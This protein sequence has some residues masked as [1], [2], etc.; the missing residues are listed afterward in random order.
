MRRSSV[1]FIVLWARFPPNQD[2]TARKRC[3]PAPAKVRIAIIDA[4]ASTR[5]GISHF[6]RKTPEWEVIW[7]SATG[8][9]AAE[10]FSVEAPQMLILDIRLPDGSGLDL[11]K[12]FL[13]LNP[14]LLILVYTMESEEFYAWRC[15][16]A[17][18]CGY[19][20]KTALMTDFKTVL[21]TILQ[22]E[23]HFPAEVASKTLRRIR[24]RRSKNDRKGDHWNIH[25]LTD[26][27]IEVLQL[28]GLGRSSA[29]CAEL[30]GIKPRTL[31][32]H[33]ANIRTKIGLS[34]SL[35]LRTYATMLYIETN[36][37]RGKGR[38]PA[39]RTRNSDFSLPPLLP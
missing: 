19:I 11:I 22:G 16:E 28:I 39:S 12:R 35:Q 10:K 6:L 25:D 21:E 17:G 2:M 15:I 1:F 5:I 23:L 37:R 20:R 34:S 27:E 7:A 30:L 31:E 24:G 9:E 8:S 14:K 36:D 13:N 18:A 29:E 32:V 26:R 38:D 33:R 4:Q 3:R